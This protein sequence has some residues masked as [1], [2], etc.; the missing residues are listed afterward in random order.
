MHTTR[1]HLVGAAALTLA[2]AVAGVTS[3]AAQQRTT[4]DLRGTVVSPI[5]DFADADLSMGLGFGGT[6]AVRLQPHLHLYGGWDWIRFH[7]DA[8]FAGTDVDFEETGYT[9]GLRFQHPV[10]WNERISCRLEAGALYKH[11]E[12]EDADGDLIDDSG[13]GLGF[14]AG[15]GLS[16]VFGEKWNVVPMVRLRSHAPS[17]T[18]GSTTTDA[19]MRYV[20]FELGFSRRF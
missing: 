17:F 15:A 9:L 13:H 4:L 14:E 20:G 2:I 5:T 19:T 1:S 12:I 11:I 6:V 16:M 3:T 8:S 7:S 10:P 18:I